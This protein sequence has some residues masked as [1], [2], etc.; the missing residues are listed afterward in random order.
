[1]VEDELRETLK[2][3]TNQ[4]LNTILIIV[5]IALLI[6]MYG[7]NPSKDD[8]IRHYTR[9]YRT[10]YLAINAIVQK[11]SQFVLE[12]NIDVNNYIFFSTYTLH[13]GNRQERYIGFCNIFC[14]AE[15]YDLVYF[16]PNLRRIRQ[17]L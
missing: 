13:I 14:S 12:D 11:T 7:S 17:S 16:K 3:F 2:E 15:I 9:E 4:S 6:F 1:M 8:F 10:E 5:L